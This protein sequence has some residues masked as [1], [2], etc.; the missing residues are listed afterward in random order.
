MPRFRVNESSLTNRPDLSYVKHSRTWKTSPDIIQ[1]AESLGKIMV[2][3][4]D[5]SV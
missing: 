3:I 4:D 1:E 5:M 2:K